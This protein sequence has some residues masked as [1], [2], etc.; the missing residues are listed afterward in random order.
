MRPPMSPPLFEAERPHFSPK[1][2]HLSPEIASLAPEMT[3]VAE[4]IKRVYINLLALGAV[5]VARN[6]L[7]CLI[8]PPTM[9]CNV[10][11]R[12]EM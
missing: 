2:T 10:M 6:S 12:N 7:P 11:W 3:R 5:G 9:Q 1:I 4:S 8:A